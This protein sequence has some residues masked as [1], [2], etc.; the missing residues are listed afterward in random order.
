MTGFFCKRHVAFTSRQWQQK[1]LLSRK[2][3]QMEQLPARHP[4]SRQYRSLHQAI[5]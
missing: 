1:G 5:P 4:V 2:K 3:L